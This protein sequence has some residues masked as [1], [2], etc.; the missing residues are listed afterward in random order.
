VQAA[1]AQAGDEDVL[2]QGL[3]RHHIAETVHTALRAAGL[4]VPDPVRR[5]CR[6]DVDSGAVA[7]RAHVLLDAFG[8]LQQ[9]LSQAGVPVL[10]LKGAVLGDRLYGGTGQRPQ[11]D[12][13]ALVPT[14]DAGR[15]RRVATALGYAIGER[16]QHAVSLHRGVVKVDL[17]SALR[18]SPAYAI[19]EASIWRDA[20]PVEI[21]QLSTRTLSDEHL[22][23]LLT[24]SAA[25]DAGLGM[26]KL[27]Q[28]CDL[29]LLLREVDALT[30]WERWFAARRG[31]RLEAV[32][33]NGFALTLTGLGRTTD[34]PRLAEALRARESL[35]RLRGQGDAARLIFAPRGAEENMAWFGSFYPGSLLWYRVRLFTGG[36][37]GSVR[38]LRPQRYLRLPRRRSPAATGPGTSPARRWPRAG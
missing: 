27:K 25:A 37:P 10:L 24:I 33:A 32:A 19:D 4:P 8:E 3:R 26:V 36:F 20:V 13:D 17:H 22:L 18:S 14:A 16:D 15:A 6:D 5:A 9:A 38:E 29:W 2:A 31:E 12:V 30:P 11:F 21:E 7:R 23:T 35:L 1:L 28:L 34:A